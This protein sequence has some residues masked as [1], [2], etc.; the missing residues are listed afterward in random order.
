MEEAG[1]PL[2]EALGVEGFFE[3]EEFVIQVVAELV[4]EIVRRTANRR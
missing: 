2:V 4:E 3:V 1:F